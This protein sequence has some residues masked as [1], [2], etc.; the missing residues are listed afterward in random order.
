VP[1]ELFRVPPWAAS[2]RIARRRERVAWSPDGRLA[3][4]RFDS[5]N[6]DTLASCP[7]TAMR[8]RSRSRALSQLLG[9]RTGARGRLVHLRTNFVRQSIVE[10]DVGGRSPHDL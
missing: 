2:R 7:P 3:L 10:F 4:A 1:F 6:P 8:R 9:R 5:T